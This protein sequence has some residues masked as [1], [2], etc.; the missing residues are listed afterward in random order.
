M[1]ENKTVPSENS[2]S[3]QVNKKKNDKENN[4]VFLVLIG[5]VLLIGMYAYDKI[6]W[7]FWSFVELI[8][9]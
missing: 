8:I 9:K 2:N 6:L 1:E 5:V 7:R 3:N 4:K